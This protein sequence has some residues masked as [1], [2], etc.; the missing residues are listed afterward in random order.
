MSF[1]RLGAPIPV[2]QAPEQPYAK[3]IFIVFTPNG[4]MKYDHLEIGRA[5]ATL[6]S[7]LVGHDLSRLWNINN[8]NFAGFSKDGLY[9]G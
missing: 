3:F 4:S 5:M 9:H 1:V 8:M 7:N 6:M 2:P